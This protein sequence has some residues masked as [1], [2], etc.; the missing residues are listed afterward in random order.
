MKLNTSVA[1]RAG[2]I[3]AV[4]GL[5]VGV[6]GR[7]PFLGCLIAP[8]G[9]VVAVATGALYV[10]FRAESGGSVD[11]AEGADLLV[12]ESSFPDGE[13]VEGHLTPSQA[14]HIATL[15]GVERLV[16]IHFYPEC[17]HTDIAA[18][19]G[20]SYGGELILGSDFLSLTV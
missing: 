1:M 9:W 11:L 13:E 2:L 14:G 5:V 3:G 7:I 4:A 10:H 16:L 19:A 12:L 20:K 8:L 17:L 18:Q 6:L 15:A